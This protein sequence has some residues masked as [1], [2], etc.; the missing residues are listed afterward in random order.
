MNSDSRLTKA[1][2]VAAATEWSGDMR[3]N[4][5]TAI[6]ASKVLVKELDKCKEVVGWAQAVL[7][8]LNIGDIKSG[9]PLHLKL[10][11]VMIKY[12]EE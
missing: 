9:S 4:F 12:R 11:E 3:V 5:T 10:R 8:A 6:N 2:N 7:T 1:R